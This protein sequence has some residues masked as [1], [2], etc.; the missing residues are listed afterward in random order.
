MSW[1]SSAGESVARS[2]ETGAKHSRTSAIWAGTPGQLVL[3]PWPVTTAVLRPSSALA[4][5]V[6]CS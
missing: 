2:F 4:N 3:H 5:S 1:P 6:T